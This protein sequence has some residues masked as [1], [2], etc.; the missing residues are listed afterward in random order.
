[1]DNVLIIS[2]LHAPFIR[3]GYLEHC[4][5]IKEKHKCNKIIFIGDLI[6][7]HYSSFWE[8]NPDGLSAGDELESATIQLKK[9]YKEFP[10]A[11]V[12]IG[13]HDRLVLRKAFS[14]GVSKKWIRDYAD[15]LETPNWDFQ[16][17]YELDNVLYLHGEG[18]F[19][20]INAVLNKR[21]NLVIGH[22]H[23]KAEIIYNASE[24]DLLWGMAVGS[25]VDDKTY[26][27]EYGRFNLKKSIISCGVIINGNPYLEPM[28]L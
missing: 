9:W 1:M 5:R 4:K 13:N 7:N 27:M 24:K 21:K 18:C 28:K 16:I 3:K 2:D 17:Q 26:A 8:T 6:D 12:I 14:S 10:K 25:G 11:V 19:N 22:F 15:V 20:L 23:S